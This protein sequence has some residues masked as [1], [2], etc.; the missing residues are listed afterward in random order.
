[1]FGQ[2]GSPVNNGGRTLGMGNTGVVNK[3][4]TSV[5]SNQAGLAYITSI[6]AGVFAS[7][8]FESADIN[9]VGAA[10]AYPTKSGTFGIDV[11]YYGFEGFNEQSVGL[12]YG[13]K[14]FDK[15]A[16]LGLSYI[17]CGL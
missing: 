2:N 1:M 7:R 13:R 14:L 15:L 11:N 8:R 12:N 16:I 17:F 6:Q 5:Y 4:L 3:D 9:S 10:F